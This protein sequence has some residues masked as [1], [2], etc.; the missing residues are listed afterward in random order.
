[1]ALDLPPRLRPLADDLHRAGG[2]ALLVGGAVRDHLLGQASKDLDLEVF[3]LEPTEIER[4]LRRHGKVN[5]VGR[6]FGVFKVRLGRHEID[7]SLP[8]R[9]SKVGPGHRG[10]AVKGDP[11][12]TVL[13]A[14]RRRDLTI[15]AIL[16]DPRTGEVIDPVGGVA[17]LQ[18]RVLRAVDP[19]AFL[20][21]PLRAV[22]VAQF[23][24]RL[25]FSVDPALVELC[26][27][28]AVEELPP[29]RIWTE[30]QKLLIRG[31]RPSLG[32]AFLRQAR[33]NARLFPELVDDPPLDH[34]MDRAVALARH[35]PEPGPRLAAP[36]IVWLA[37]TAAPA[38]VATLDRLMVHRHGGYPLRDRVLAAHAAL[39]ASPTT[40]ADLRHLARRAELRIWF[41]A[42]A[43]L[44]PEGAANLGPASPATLDQWTERIDALALW[45]TPP[46]PLIQGRDLIALG[47]TP[48]PS[49]GVQLEA[50]Y[51]RQ[52]DGELTTREA[53]LKAARSLLTAKD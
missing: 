17:D 19:S 32:L 40:D 51:L 26:A 36:M 22:R 31:Q 34:A 42:R 33:L 2:R 48:G 25:D 52:L 4:I 3:G 35:L 43:A 11:S 53:A 30:W 15:N 14:A 8:R 16:L 49:V 37:N 28:A 39:P 1:M 44:G 45:T 23:A 21:D 20:E 46:P 7:V 50:L 24:A 6:A 27:T 12:M 5:T 9:D 29:E 18:R 47:A 10:I 41:I 38:A 13:E